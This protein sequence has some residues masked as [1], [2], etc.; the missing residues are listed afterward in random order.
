M[1]FNNINWKKK[2]FLS[3]GYMEVKLSKGKYMIPGTDAY[4]YMHEGQPV[5][6]YA[7]DGVRT[8]GVIPREEDGYSIERYLEWLSR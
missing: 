8:L 1:L 5:L 2:G 3:A 4:I 6:S 7:V